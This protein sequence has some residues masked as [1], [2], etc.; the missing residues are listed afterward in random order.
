MRAGRTFP[1]PPAGAYVGTNIAY[2]LSRSA[3]PFIHLSSGTMGN[4]GA[5]TAVTALPRTY[6]DGAWCLFPAGAV[7]AGVPAAASWLWVV[8]SSATAGTVFNSTYTSGT[9]ALGAQTAFVTTGPGAFTGDITERMGPGIT[10]PGNALG[11]SGQITTNFTTQ[12]NNTVG[13]KSLR[14]RLGGVGGTLTATITVTS[15]ASVAGW[16]RTCAEGAANRQITDGMALQ[17]ASAT[18]IS[19]AP[20]TTQ[21][22]LTADQ[23]V[24]VTLTKLV[25]TDNVILERWDHIVEYAP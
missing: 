16:I 5:L 17:H 23:V 13:G 7:A 4:N 9:V 25:A 3:I 11:P 21:A 1:V 2:A 20:A 8:F 19:Q 15:T 10:L 22:D 12:T 24:A 14:T 18:M 6:S